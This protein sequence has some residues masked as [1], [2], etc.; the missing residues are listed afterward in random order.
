LSQPILGVSTDFLRLN[1]IISRSWSGVPS[2][3]DTPLAVVP[4]ENWLPP[5]LE[6]EHAP[7]VVPDTLVEKH[8]EALLRTTC[9]AALVGA[10]ATYNDVDAG[11]EFILMNPPDSLVKPMDELFNDTWQDVMASRGDQGL[12]G[13]EDTMR[14]TSSLKLCDPIWLTVQF[15]R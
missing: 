15:A 8:R 2:T 10:G 12:S 3:P 4:P 14:G 13:E 7:P 11:S 9:R 1:H 6:S 5:A